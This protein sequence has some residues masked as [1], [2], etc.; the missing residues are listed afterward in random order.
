[1]TRFDDLLEVQRHDTNADQL[2]HRREHLPERAQL[3]AL[4]NDMAALDARAGEVEARV[5]ELRRA[6]KKLEDEIA[7]LN[8]KAQQVDK[9]L[10]G[11]TVSVPKDLQA[12][13]S[14]LEHIR[15]RVSTLEDDEL[16]LMEQ[17]EP[18]DAELA[19]IRETRASLERDA[20]AL[21]GVI[22]EQ[23]AAIDAELADVASMRDKAAAPVPAELLTEYERLR[24]RLGV[25]VAPLSGGVCGGCHL[26]LSAVEIDRIRT[27]PADELVHCE[28][29]GRLLVHS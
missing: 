27:L 17:A 10:Y 28:E 16:E 15:Q 5:D 14:E 11:G 25:A 18:I 3:A 9:T 7:S 4:R 22:V 12:L 23:E 1:M 20:E 21:T 24:A 8:D 29:C 13:Q 2:R 19:S 6:Q 26:K